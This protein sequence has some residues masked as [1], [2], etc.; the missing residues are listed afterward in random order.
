M[1]KCTYLTG[2]DGPHVNLVAHCLKILGLYQSEFDN[3]DDL[4][5][6]TESNILEQYYR[7]CIPN[8]CVLT[9]ELS[10]ELL[11]FLARNKPQMSSEVI[12]DNMALSCLNYVKLF[13][14]GQ[15]VYIKYSYEDM[16]DVFFDNVDKT[17]YEKDAELIKEAKA[18]VDE[19][20]TW[21]FINIDYKKFISDLDYRAEALDRISGG[22]EARQNKDL[23]SDEVVESL[24]SKYNDLYSLRF[25]EDIFAD[26]EL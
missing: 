8:N 3:E 10:R 24:V 14:P 16:N 26:D 21:D 2:F 22:Y 19:T 23:I 25:V 9:E 11:G 5:T 17:V 12:K 18:I 4:V 20:D 13:L 15:I 7:S 6:Y 1:K